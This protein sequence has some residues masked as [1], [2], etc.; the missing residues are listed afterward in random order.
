M[1]VR[2]QGTWDGHWEV[3]AL[4]GSMCWASHGGEPGPHRA[5]WSRGLYAAKPPPT[6][7]PPS[8]TPEARVPPVL[9]WAC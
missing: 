4:Q 3:C 6:P 7:K 8:R 1:E 2:G 5:W 9:T